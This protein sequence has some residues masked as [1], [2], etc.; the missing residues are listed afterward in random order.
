MMRWVTED[1]DNDYD[2]DEHEDKEGAQ[3]GTDSEVSAH[4]RGV[5]YVGIQSYFVWAAS[6]VSGL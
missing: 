3:S 1:S 6:L 2:V 4:G 5:H